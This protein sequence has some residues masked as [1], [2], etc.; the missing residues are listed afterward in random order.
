MIGRVCQEELGT[1]PFLTALAS[2]AIEPLFL[3]TLLFV[4]AG[5]VAFATGSSWATM[6]ILMP[7]VIGL[8]FGLG[9]DAQLLDDATAS[10]QRLVVIS[11]A[12]VLS[13]S[14][15]GDH[16]SP[17]S[18]TTVMSSIASASDHIDHVRTQAPYALIVMLISVL[19]GYVPCTFLGISPW[20]SLLTGA[21]LVFL[22]V[23]F[24]GRPSACP[25]ADPVESI[26]P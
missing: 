5:V 20:L 7:L 17:I 10:G 16:C 8:A 24:M 23:R 3:P 25:A 13:G 15:F 4:L 12:A 1:A 22:L 18:D 19:V 2:K 14:I 11:V 9:V 21:V 26:A 6:S